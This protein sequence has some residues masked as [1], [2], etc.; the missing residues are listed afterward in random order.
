VKRC[1]GAQKVA[2]REL[3]AKVG[4]RLGKQCRE[5]WFFH[6]DPAILR[7]P[8]SVEDDK[9]LF[10]LRCQLGA[11]RDAPGMTPCLERNPPRALRLSAVSGAW[12]AM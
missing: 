5:R 4:G 1:G 9:T 7:T 10:T 8:F 3:A 2:W 6:L 12:R 11:C